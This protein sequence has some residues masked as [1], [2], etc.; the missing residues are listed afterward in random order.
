MDALDEC[1]NTSYIPSPRDEVLNLIKEFIKSHIP[2]LRMCVTSRPETEIKDVFDPLALHATSLHN[3]SGQ[4]G[5]IEE[6]ITDTL[7]ETYERTLREFKKANWEFAHCLFQFVAVT[8]RLLRV[9]E[10]AE[11]L[12]F[13]FKAGPTPKFH[14]DW[15]LEDPMHAIPST[16]PGFLAIVDDVVT[17]ARLAEANNIN[18]RRYHISETPAQSLAASACL[19]HLL[20]L[21]KDV[22]RDSLRN[23]PFAEY[24]AEYLVSH[25]RLEDVSRNVKDGLKKLFD[26]S[27]PHL[28]VCVWI[29][30]KS[31]SMETK[32]TI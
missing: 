24:S 1:L 19:G 10:L 18:S 6:H 8:V 5:D 4:K 29:R 32:A 13:D 17:S 20:H 28:A 30:P 3:E 11:W 27:K 9:E 22:T 7:D 26:P 12:A 21:D 2:N 23:L 25:A 16:C 15:R 14:E 31:S